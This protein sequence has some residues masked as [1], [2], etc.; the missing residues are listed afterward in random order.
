MTSPNATLRRLAARVLSAAMVL[1]ALGCLGLTALQAAPAEAVA[2]APA[3]FNIIVFTSDDMDFSSINANGN[4]VP[5]LTP[6]ID[7]LAASGMTFE[8]AHVPNAVCQ[9]SRQSMM[10]GLHPH[11]NGSLGFDPPAPGTPNLSEL[12]MAEGWLTFTFSKGRDYRSSQWTFFQDGHG[13]AGF[14]REPARFAADVERAIGRA[15]TE[16][17]PFFLNVP[18]SD[19]HRAYP[20]SADEAKR[21]SEAKK[22]WPEA[23]ARGDIYYPPY[24]DICSPKQA[25]VPPYLPDLPAVRE[26]W[27]HYYRGVRRADET[28]G[29]VLDKLEA[30]GLAD[31]TVVIFYADNGAS[32]PTSKQN[33]YPY[34]TQCS[35]I[36][37]WPGVTT[38]GTRDRDHFVSTMDLLPTILQAT[39]LP[40]PERLDGKSLLPLLRGAKQAGR[41]STMTTQN[42]YQPGFQVYPMRALH[43]AAFTYIFNAWADGNT[44][45]NGE[46]HSGLTFAAIADAAKTD[47]TVAARLRHITHR[48]PE[49]LYDTRADPWCLRNL[50]EEPAHAYALAAHRAALEREMRQTEDPLLPKFLGT[51]PIP[52]EWMQ[53]REG[54]GK[55][56]KR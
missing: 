9:P 8:R 24:Q 6:N 14:G 53:R 20:G 4:P 15:R 29:L 56:K 28:L 48:T 17:K 12:L 13:T 22:R 54:A 43:T 5:G 39:R 3:A 42:F 36:I 33:C 44:Q 41:D 32:F 18:V 52:P 16:A 26:E 11:R 21:L 19:P 34:S 25:W 50:A 7:R 31:S 49:E 1:P 27:A 40:L 38:P 23:D 2:P 51:S 37:R 35:L 55:K 46:C 47:P 30:D 10:T 45:F